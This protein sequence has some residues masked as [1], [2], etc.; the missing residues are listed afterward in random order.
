MLFTVNSEKH[1]LC[2]ICTQNNYL[3]ND[4][5]QKSWNFLLVEN[6]WE[7]NAGVFNIQWF[8]NFFDSRQKIY[9][10]LGAVMP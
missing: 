1:N 6:K 9:Q 8:S 7:K 10:N 5:L 3:Q 4:R 2:F